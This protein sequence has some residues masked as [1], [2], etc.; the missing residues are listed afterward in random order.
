[1]VHI[2]FN[3]TL[4]DAPILF[5]SAS[6]LYNKFVILEA[7]MAKQTEHRQHAHFSC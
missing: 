4:S 5:S 1:M 6:I 3:G 2:K 7:F